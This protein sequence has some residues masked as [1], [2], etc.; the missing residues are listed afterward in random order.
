MLKDNNIEISITNRNRKYFEDL[1]YLINSNKL[2]IKTI[3]LSKNSHVRVSVICDICKKEYNL[4]YAKYFQN[5]SHYNFFTCKKCST[6]KKKLTNIERF[7][8]DNY[9]KLENCKFSIKQTKLER[10]GNKNYNNQEKSKE[11]MLEKYGVEF[12]LQTENFL[13]NFRDKRDYEYKKN[14]LE[15]LKIKGVIEIDDNYNYIMKCEK[16]H[17]FK[18]DSDTI[19]NRTRNYKSTILCTVCNPVGSHTQSGQEILLREFIKNN[20]NGLILSNYKKIGKEIDI[21][22]PDLNLGF[23]FNGTYW[24]NELYKLKNYHLNKTE[25]CEK[26]SIKLIHIYQDDWSYKQ[27]IVKS[28]ILNLLGKSNKIMARKCEIKELTDNKLVRE[29]LKIN[30]LQGFVGS[31][32]KIGLFYNEELV[33]LMTFGSQRKAMGQKSIEG[34]YEMLRF[35]NKLNTNV[36]G[37]A[38]RLF[39]YFIK[40]YNPLE[41]ISYADRSWSQGELY[42]QLRFELVHKTKPN[43]YYVVD[44]VR[45]HRFGFRKDKLIREGADPNKTEHEIMLERKVYRIY[46]SGN[47]KYSFK[48]TI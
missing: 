20:Y 3:D 23:E 40:N 7:G 2:I 28:R 25:L 41:V 26:N 15:K 12:F 14:L 6:E 16:E 18:I 11:T 42:K 45:K 38:S 1:G 48:T 17:I 39:K 34:S 5:I 35:C 47:M 27:D 13:E 44:G 10:Y 24:H 22:L 4:M 33:S 32:V 36:I 8:V 31:Q 37:G 30:H 43:Y 46:D 21:Y 19:L 9:A 29:F